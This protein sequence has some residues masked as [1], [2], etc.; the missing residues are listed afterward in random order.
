MLRTNSKKA[1]QNIRKYI[2]DNADFSNYGIETPTDYKQVCHIIMHIFY[3]E[4][5]KNNNKRMSY[6]EMFIYW[7]SGLPS[8]FDSCYYYNRSAVTDVAMILDETAEEANRYTEEQAEQ[9]LSCLIWRE[10][11]KA[12]NYTIK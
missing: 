5:V 12:C 1:L 11:Y 4:F 3:D 6:Q 8:A 2:V 7:L 9:L 10:V